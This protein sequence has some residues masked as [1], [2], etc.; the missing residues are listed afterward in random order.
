MFK[1]KL[2]SKQKSYKLNIS[3]KWSNVWNISI[4]NWYMY[5]LVTLGMPRPRINTKNQ[6]G[7]L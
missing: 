7:A 3:L 2:Y 4:H 6:P 1:V 5:D